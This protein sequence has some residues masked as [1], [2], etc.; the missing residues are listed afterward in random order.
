[1]ETKLVVNINVP[2]DVFSTDQSLCQNMESF[3]QNVGP[4]LNGTGGSKQRELVAV[5]EIDNS[6]G[7]CFKIEPLF[8]RVG[9]T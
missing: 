8:V 7:R 4:N 3:I 5:L 9:D 2:K 6:T 1:M